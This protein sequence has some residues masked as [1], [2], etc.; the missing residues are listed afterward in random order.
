MKK[1]NGITLVALIITIIVMLI[2]VAVTINVAINGGLFNRAQTAKVQ[3]EIESE[4]ELIN[5]AAAVAM[6]MDRENGIITKD[7]LTEAL[8]KSKPENTT[9]EVLEEKVENETNF[10]I[11]FVEKDRYYKLTQDGKIGA[12]EYVKDPTPGS[13]ATDDPNTYEIWSIEDLV[14]FRNMSSGNGMIID[15]NGQAV[16]VTSKTKTNFSGK[17]VKL[18]KDLDFKSSLS[19]TNAKRTDYG[20]INGDAEDGN[21]LIT[22]MT[23]GTGFKPIKSFTGSFDGQ[24]FEIKNI[25]INTTE[26]AGLFS[27]SKVNE[28]RNLTI[29]GDITSTTHAAGLIGSSYGSANLIENCCNKANITAG[30]FASGMTNGGAQKIENCCNKANITGSGNYTAGIGINGGKIINCYNEGNI[31]NNTT[32]FAVGGIALNS[33]EIENCY[34]TGTVM[35]ASGSACGIGAAGT[36]RNCYNTGNISRKTWGWNY[37]FV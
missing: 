15:E 21:A 10:V 13:I 16:E 26:E 9:I 34:N 14:A 18:M 17:T 5:Q 20:D 29:S 11:G 27:S 4:K 3:T 25:Y 35:A 1:E 23:T 8:N 2:L 12:Y 30:S 32:I 33:Q 6:M 37:S 24:G 36:I 7:N 31:T 22:E 28:I 19:Y